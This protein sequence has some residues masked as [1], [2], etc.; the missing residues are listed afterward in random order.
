MVELRTD[1]IKS[2]YWANEAEYTHELISFAYTAT[3]FGGR[4]RWLVCPS[5]GSPR[6]ALFRAMKRFRCRKCLGLVYQSTREPSQQRVLDQADKLAYRVAGAASDV[7]ERDDFPEKPKR[8]RWRTYW[9]LEERYYAY[10]EAWAPLPC[11]ASV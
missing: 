10:M 4:R 6:R 2:H 3:Q 9:R 8:M 7:C 5:C 1:G 11:G